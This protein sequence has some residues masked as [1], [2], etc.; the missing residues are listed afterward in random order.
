LQASGARLAHAVGT[1]FWKNGTGK[2]IGFIGE[3]YRGNASQ[4]EIAAGA[5]Q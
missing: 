3:R 1:T 5:N 2:Y 4:G